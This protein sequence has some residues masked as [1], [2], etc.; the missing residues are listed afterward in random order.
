MQKKIFMLNKRN[1]FTYYMNYITKHIKILQIIVFIS[2]A[3]T[4]SLTS[5]PYQQY[6]KICVSMHDIYIPNSTNFPLVFVN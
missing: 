6:K 2:K 1:I 3:H 5:F 4:F